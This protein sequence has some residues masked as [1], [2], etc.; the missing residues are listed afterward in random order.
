MM[1]ETASRSPSREPA[2]SAPRRLLKAANSALLKL[3]RR[4]GTRRVAGLGPVHLMIEPGAV[5]GLSCALCPT[6]RGELKLSKGLMPLEKY[7]EIVERLQ[8]SLR[9]ISLYNW[10]EPLLHPDILRMIEFSESRGIEVSL[11]SSLNHFPAGMPEG[12]VRSGL[13]EL[14]VAIDGVRQSSY[15]R[16]RRGGSLRRVFRNLLGI[17]QAKRSLRSAKPRLIWQFLVF[18][19]ND[20]E[21][22]RAK[23]LAA[24]LSV[25][26]RPLIGIVGG[27]EAWCSE[28]P[29]FGKAAFRRE[30]LRMDHCSALW[31]G[32]VIHADGKVLP[33]CAVKDERHS[34]GNV[35]EQDFLEIWNN[36]KF[37]AARESVTGDP[38]GRGDDIPCAGCPYHP[39][40][41]RRI[42]ER[43]ASM[44]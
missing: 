39:G 7:E 19:H 33:C 20:A 18:R 24:R 5:C 26:F 41:L 36:R 13:S 8:G 42:D 40:R 1:A 11:S 44:I 34:C 27:R 16:L 6:G 43:P 10:G 23:A 37:Q 30:K 4:L 2:A 3:Q 9:R 17:L 25:E 22:E 31:L 21:V 12:L 14:I 28:R 32:P 15:G 29:P 35:F 38:G